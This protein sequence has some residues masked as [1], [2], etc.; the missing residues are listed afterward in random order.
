MLHKLTWGRRNS[1]STARPVIWTA[2]TDD[3][4]HAVDQK[5]EA[6]GKVRRMQVDLDVLTEHLAQ[7]RENAMSAE[8][9]R[10]NRPETGVQCEPVRVDAAVQ[11]SPPIRPQAD[12]AV[13]AGARTTAI[14][15][16]PTSTVF[17]KPLPT[18]AE[19]VLDNVMFAFLQLVLP[20]AAD[21]ELA[22]TSSVLADVHMALSSLDSTSVRNS[23]SPPESLD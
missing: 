1:D 16:T 13:Q 9:S 17:L 20:S 4:R 10:A 18:Y 2:M 22:S 14:R 23:P 21:Q 7:V 6:E 12:A 19:P 11:H 5:E 3:L 8:T 15:G